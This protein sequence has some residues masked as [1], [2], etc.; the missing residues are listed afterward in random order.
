MMIIYNSLSWIKYSEI[1]SSLFLFL[2]LESSTII[3]SS[4]SLLCLY[5]MTEGDNDLN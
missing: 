1:T 3:P 2:D 5:T 4:E